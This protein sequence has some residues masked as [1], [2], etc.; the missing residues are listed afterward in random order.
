M[1][2]SILANKTKYEMPSKIAIAL[3]LFNNVNMGFN[4]FSKI[5][6]ISYSIEFLTNFLS[7]SNFL[8]ILKGYGKQSKI[9]IPFWR[10]IITIGHIKGLETELPLTQTYFVKYN[11]S[12]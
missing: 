2:S 11:H 3:K 8:V 5:P 4:F 1:T 6:M 12:I 7:D 9:R 10:V